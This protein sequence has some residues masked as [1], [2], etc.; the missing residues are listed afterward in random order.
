MTE[1]FIIVVDMLIVEWMGKGGE[2]SGGEL[3]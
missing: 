3:E 1:I 2:G